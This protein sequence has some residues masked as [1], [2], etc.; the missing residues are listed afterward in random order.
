MLEDCFFQLLLYNFVRKYHILPLKLYLIYKKYRFPLCNLALTLLCILKSKLCKPFHF[1]LKS[2]LNLINK[3]HL[4][5]LDNY[6][7]NF[8]PMQ[9]ILKEKNICS[10]SKNK[11]DSYD[12]FLREALYKKTFFFHYFFKN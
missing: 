5:F 1:I 6:L 3:S 9:F 8:L 11:I 12:A 7:R 2:N 10:I 4:K